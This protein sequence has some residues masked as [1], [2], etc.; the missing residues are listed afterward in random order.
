MKTKNIS[1]LLVAFGLCCAMS[2]TAQTR[3]PDGSWTF[4]MPY[5]SR[6]L[7]VVYYPAYNITY[8]LYGGSWEEGKENPDKYYEDTPTFTLYNPVRAGF[9]FLGW[10]ENGTQEP[11]NPVTITTS[12]TGDKIFDAVWKSRIP[13][14]IEDV[15][16]DEKQGTKMIR[17]GLLLIECDGVRYN[18]QGGLV[19]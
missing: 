15:Q 8:N 2:M 17:D 18:A 13:A 16:S 4:E 9:D 1:L 19:D 3:Q 6:L 10:I 12:T 11:Q 14:A 5:G 7:N